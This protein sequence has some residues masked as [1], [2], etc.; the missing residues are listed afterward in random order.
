[1]NERM[2]IRRMQVPERQNDDLEFDPNRDITEEKWKQI[3][4][5]FQNELK[6][7]ERWLGHPESSR[8]LNSVG[9]LAC[10]AISLQILGK[11][12]PIS[13]DVLHDMENLAERANTKSKTIYDTALFA[14]LKTQGMKPQISDALWKRFRERA[15][16]VVHGGDNFADGDV[17]YVI[18]SALID[19]T[20]LAFDDEDIAATTQEMESQRAKGDAYSFSKFAHLAVLLK[21]LRPGALKLTKKDWNGMRS[22]LEWLPNNL[23]SS[24]ASATMCMT[25]LAA[26]EVHVTDKGIEVAHH[27]KSADKKMP[28]QPGSLTL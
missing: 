9:G 14:F 20:K 7:V 17:R 21:I 8:D 6:T 27:N 18:D 12:T 19:P 15:K 13:E 22:Y 23:D 25:L 11:P 1:M 4:E 26:D 5:E 3:E 28:T 10:E 2:N 16:F 24:F